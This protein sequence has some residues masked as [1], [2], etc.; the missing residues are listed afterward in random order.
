MKNLYAYNKKIE[1]KM[2][3][4]SKIF[5]QDDKA[6]MLTMFDG[7]PYEMTLEDVI[8]KY[9]ECVFGIP[10]SVCKKPLVELNDDDIAVLENLE[11]SVMVFSRN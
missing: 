11:D 8:L 6:A 1:T 3:Y 2:D 9:L 4:M 7:D 10:A 5:E